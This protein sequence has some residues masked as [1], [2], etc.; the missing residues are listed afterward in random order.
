[1]VIRPMSECFPKETRRMRCSTSRVAKCGSPFNRLTASRQSSPFFP[2]AA[3]YGEC[4]LAGQTVRSATASALLP[5]TI[6]RIEKQATLD[7]LRSDPE[8]AERFRTYMLS[9]IL[10][11]E[12]DLV[13]HLL[14]SSE[15]RLARMRGM[16]SKCRTEWKPTPVTAKLSPESLAEII[17]T[18]SS[19]VSFI[20]DGF[21]ELGFIDS[22]GD[23]MLVHGSLMSIV[24]HDNGIC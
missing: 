1:M 12:A 6:V 19:N 16:K 22:S 2:K 9:R 13:S 23:E 11:M 18:T 20:L 5:S 24:Q 8:F 3:S 7:L 4:C 14:E 17:G 21:R 10:C 15:K